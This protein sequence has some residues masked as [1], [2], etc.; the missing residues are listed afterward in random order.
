MVIGGSHVKGSWSR[1]K[2]D[3]DFSPMLHL[4]IPSNVDQLLICIMILVTHFNSKSQGITFALS[5]D[6]HSK[7]I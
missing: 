6:I 4:I 5:K 1:V 3:F 7:I 2:T